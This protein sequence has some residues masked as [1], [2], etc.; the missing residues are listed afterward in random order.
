MN[1]NILIMAFALMLMM[2]IVSATNYNE[3]KCPDTC[4]DNTW[5]HGG[6]YNFYRDRCD[7][8][9]TTCEFGCFG[10]KCAEA[11]I[12]ETPINET[13]V[14]EPVIVKKHQKPYS[15]PKICLADKTSGLALYLKMNDEVL[16]NLPGRYQQLGA[17][18]VSD[19]QYKKCN[20]I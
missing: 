3:K 20:E 18:V 13:P 12:N 9:K 19:Y 4:S 17:I 11:P 2:N 6:S 14:I 15:Y 10:N 16:L 1:K 7:Y 5:R 8:V